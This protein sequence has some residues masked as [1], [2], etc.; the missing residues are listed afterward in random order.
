MYFGSDCVLHVMVK[1]LRIKLLIQKE[2][3]HEELSIYLIS[4]LH[5]L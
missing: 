4:A 5:I 2:S 3:Y 1:V